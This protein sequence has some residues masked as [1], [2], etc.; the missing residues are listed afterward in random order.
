MKG[1]NHMQTYEGYIENGYFTPIGT[2]L[3]IVGRRRAVLN[4]VEDSNSDYDN[5]SHNEYLILLNQLR[6][7]IDDPT[8]VEP[9]EIP[10]EYYSKI[11]DLE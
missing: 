7:C 2:P 3:G 8:F 5:L 10:W 4:L 1:V 9:P 6:G 11:E